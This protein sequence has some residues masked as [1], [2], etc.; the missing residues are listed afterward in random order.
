MCSVGVYQAVIKQPGQAKLYM[1]TTAYQGH[2]FLPSSAAGERACILQGWISYCLFRNTCS[3]LGEGCILWGEY[4]TLFPL[5]CNTWKCSALGEVCILLGWISHCFWQY[6]EFPSW[7]CSDLGGEVC[8]LQGWISQS[9]IFYP[10]R[11]CAACFK[12]K[13][14]QSLENSVNILLSKPPSLNSWNTLHL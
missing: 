9:Y 11:L 6:L 1:R 5:F 12:I 10:F 2:P 3:A 8:I 4:L 14:A 7:K 13:T